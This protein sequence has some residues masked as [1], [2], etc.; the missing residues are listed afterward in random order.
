MM[1]EKGNAKIEKYLFYLTLIFSCLAYTGYYLYARR[2]GIA[3]LISYGRSNKVMMQARSPLIMFFR[4]GKDLCASLLLFVEIFSMNRSYRVKIFLVMLLVTAYGT[5]IAYANNA[6]ESILVAGYRMVVFFFA[7]LMYFNARYFSPLSLKAFFKLISV[8]LILNTVIAANQAYFRLG[9]R[10]K[11]IGKGSYRF[12]GVFP[13][14]AAFAYFCLGTALFAYCIEVQTRA[15]HSYCVIIFA[16]AFIGCYLSGTRSSMINFLVIMY[17]YI[18]DKLNLLKAKRAVFLIIMALPV[19]T[20]IIRFSSKLANR[21]SILGNALGG[22]RLTIFINSIFG[23]PLINIIFGSGLGAGSN[24]AAVI[25]IGSG[26]KEV[27]IL[28]GTFTS[29]FYQFGIIGF[30]V[31]LVFLWKAASRIYSENGF[32]N[33]VLF[34]GSVVLQCLTTNVLEAFALLIMLFITYYAF[35]KGEEVFDSL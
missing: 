15:Y 17:V 10:L 5:I 25:M 29:I 13:A 20:L 2:N 30:A 9:S 22:G 3:L 18:I 16:F 31:C 11:L 28:D 1:L 6:S 24:S 23:Q 34:T 7:L 27:V 33:T 35:V 14:A 4:F 19:I 12:M 8:L 26:S 32:L 21:G